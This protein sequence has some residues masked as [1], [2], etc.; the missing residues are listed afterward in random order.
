MKSYQKI[1]HDHWYLSI[2][3][4]P[5]SLFKFVKRLKIDLN[6]PKSI[7]TQQYIYRIIED[8]TQNFESGYV[9]YSIP[10]QSNL[11][12]PM[13]DLENAGEASYFISDESH[14]RNIFN[15]I[16]SKSWDL[17]GLDGT[18][19]YHSRYARQSPSSLLGFFNVDTQ[20]NILIN[21][22]YI[23]SEKEIQEFRSYTTDILKQEYPDKYRW[24]NVI[25]STK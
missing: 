5:L 19:F 7:F 25:K 14:Y 9:L 6:K 13:P 1:N 11:D 8:T 15:F 4:S 12:Q 17:Y 16:L 2:A 18:F 22:P 20:Q 24:A 3:G 21:P 23:P 10:H